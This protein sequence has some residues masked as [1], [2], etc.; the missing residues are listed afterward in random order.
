MIPCANVTKLFRSA[1]FFCYSSLHRLSFVLI[2]TSAIFTILLILT[3]VDQ[4][5]VF[6]FN[7]IFSIASLAKC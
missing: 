4:N 2:F 1:P 7:D 5:A 3:E 6:A